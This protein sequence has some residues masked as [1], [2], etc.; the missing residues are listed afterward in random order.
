MNAYENGGH[1]L[2]T[3]DDDDTFLWRIMERSIEEAVPGLK[4]ISGAKAR[5]IEPALPPG[6]KHALIY[7]QNA[8]GLR[9]VI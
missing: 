6:V 4:I 2:V 7:P 9:S 1:M 8:A 3:F 5:E